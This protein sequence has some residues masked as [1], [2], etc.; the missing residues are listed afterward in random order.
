MGVRKLIQSLSRRTTA[1]WINDQNEKG[2]SLKHKPPQRQRDDRI[3]T[4]DADNRTSNKPRCLKATIFHNYPLRICVLI[5]AFLMLLIV[6]F[7]IIESFEGADSSQCRSI[8]M[9]PSYGRLNGF[10][11]KHTALAQKYHLYLYREQGLDKEPM[12]DG[13]A[14]LDGIPVLFIPGNAGSFKQVRS[15]AASCSRN[16]FQQREDIKNPNTRNL[17]FFAADFNEDFTAFHGRTMLDQAEYL[18]DAIRYIL[19]LYGHSSDSSTPA[20]SSVIIIGHSMGGIVARIL[21]TL[22]NHVEGSVQ[23][24]ITLSSPHAAAPVTFDGDIL[25]IYA[26]TNDFWRE[27]MQDR[28]SFFSKNMSLI[29]ITGG[30][31]DMMLPA[32]YTA[33]QDIVPLEN[34]FTTYSSTIPNVWT[35]I[36]HLAVVWCDQLR[37]VVAKLLLET[38]DYTA[39]SRLRTL[40]ERMKTSRELLLSGFENYTQHD[41]TIVNSS[42]SPDNKYA[43]LSQVGSGINDKSPETSISAIEN[44]ENEERSYQILLP[45]KGSLNL[46]ILASTEG[47]CI[48]F[49]KAK[50]PFDPKNIEPDDS[51]SCFRGINYMKYAPASFKTTGHASDSSVNSNIKPFQMMNIGNSTLSHYD[52]VIVDKLPYAKFES[53]DFFISELTI[54]GIEKSIDVTPL[55][56]ATMGLKLEL[57][58][59]LIETVS[60]PNVWDS[61]LSYKVRTHLITKE[62]KELLFQP[63]VRQWIDDPFESKWHVNVTDFDFNINMHGVAPFIPLEETHDKSLKL[64]V[65]TPPGA[66]LIL[67]FRINWGLTIKMLFIR[68]RLTF[69]SLPVSVV[70]FVLAFQFYRYQE[71]RVFPSFNNTLAFLLKTKGVYIFFGILFLSPLVNTRLIQKL[72]YFFDPVRLNRPFLLDERNMHTN[73]YFLGIRSWFLS[74]IGILFVLMSIACLFLVAKI[75]DIAEYFVRKTKLKFSSSKSGSK[76]PLRNRKIYESWKAR[77]FACII[78]TFAVLFYIPYQLASAI[79][80]IIQ[81]ITCLRVLSNAE[82]LNPEKYNNLRNYNFSVF[83]LLLFVVL[84]DSPI[85]VVFLHN[86]AIRWETP[87]RSHHNFLAIAP[88]IFLVNFNSGLKIPGFRSKKTYEGFATV[89]LLLYL[90]IFSL[91]YGSRN[92]YWIHHLANMLCAWLL[93][94][95]YA[96]SLP[97][98]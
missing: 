79:T 68:Y 53:N 5:G 34:G 65:M 57:S 22:M 24:L 32:D 96:A 25:K 39:S 7:T 83:L 10:D 16:Y 37:T 33:V 9:F 90:S 63:F 56:I 20:P 11:L 67:D 98:E 61:L 50:Y 18:N 40:E 3:A 71:I 47:L 15:I 26:R 76:S 2:S 69:L 41:L 84:I 36:D 1:V 44:L 87:F 23:S 42:I 13:M 86:V 88:T 17:D 66:K 28:D 77:I 78:L 92:L 38:A 94:G 58:G 21:P 72:L 85:I 27:Q 49:C 29:S 51:D 55:H 95:A 19:S 75:H 8:Y 14:Q 43:H 70:S 81:V 48:S 82:N 52:Y 6:K 30:I 80:L 4:T 97:E 64:A 62:T 91:I 60:F 12:K 45:K 54:N 93:Y 31:L 35:P 73:F 59:K 46:A 74:G 89:L